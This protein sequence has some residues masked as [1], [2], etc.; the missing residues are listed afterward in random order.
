MVYLSLAALGIA[1]SSG[2]VVNSLNALASLECDED[3]QSPSTEVKSNAQSQ[4][5]TQLP[6]GKTLGKF[7][8]AGQLGRAL[9]PLSITAAYWLYGPSK[10][11]TVLGASML[12]L[13]RLSRPLLLETKQKSA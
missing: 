12:V 7:R 13:A 1:W 6:K 11:Y 2:T 8:S 10:T 9:G 4:T 3:E 5:T